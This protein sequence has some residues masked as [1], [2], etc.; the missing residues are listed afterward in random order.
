MLW[1]VCFSVLQSL[2]LVHFPSNLL[3]APCSPSAKQCRAGLLQNK[4][5]KRKATPAVCGWHHVLAW[6][7]GYRTPK[8]SRNR[9]PA[10]PLLHPC[11]RQL[12]LCPRRGPLHMQDEV[13]VPI[14]L[15]RADGA[16][17]IFP[18]RAHDWWG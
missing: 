7:L 9:T 6:S 11:M 16:L 8:C 18:A 15:Q 10:K 13:V 12:A 5:P 14:A 2:L 17:C 1:L 3:Q 4:P